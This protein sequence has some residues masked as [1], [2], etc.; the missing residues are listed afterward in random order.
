MYFLRTSC[1]I[2]LNIANFNKT[3][4][5]IALMLYHQFSFS[6]LYFLKNISHHTIA[7]EKSY[8]LKACLSIHT[9]DTSPQIVSNSDTI[10]NCTDFISIYKTKNKLSPHD[11]SMIPACYKQVTEN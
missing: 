3:Y 5:L 11:I 8:E 4:V 2:D 9:L 1:Y 7:K 10:M 6:A